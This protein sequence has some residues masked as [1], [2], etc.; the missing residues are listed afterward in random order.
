MQGSLLFE[1]SESGA[2]TDRPGARKHHAAAAREYTAR[3]TGVDH[4]RPGRSGQNF[5]GFMHLGDYEES[6]INRRIWT[7]RDQIEERLA[8]LG[9][10]IE[11]VIQMYLRN[12]YETI[13]EYNADAGSIAEKYHFL[14]LADFPTNVSETA[15]RRLQSIVQSGPRCG[16][17]TLIHWDQRQQLPDGF[18]PEELRKNSISIRRQGRDFILRKSSSKPVPHSCSRCRPSRISRPV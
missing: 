14:V 6:L 12:E 8:E 16:I 4:H 9:E 13:T 7:Q 1:T 10:H 3:Q 2:G 15:A 11:K 17:F 18:A 5:A